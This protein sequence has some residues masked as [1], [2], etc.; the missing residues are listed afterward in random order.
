M[1]LPQDLVLRALSDD[2]SFRLLSA[3]TTGRCRA[4]FRRPEAKNL[5]ARHFGDL[6]TGTVLVRET[7][8]PELRVQGIVRAKGG[9]YTLIGDSF[10]DGGT[11]GLVNGKQGAGEIVLGGD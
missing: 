5:T 8:A 7:M 1:P 4:A 6:L 3:R 9:N 2:R 10:P 11:R